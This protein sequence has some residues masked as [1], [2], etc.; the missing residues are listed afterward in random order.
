V[1]VYGLPPRTPE[2]VVRLAL[3]RFGVIEAVKRQACSR[4]IKVT[5]T[6]CFQQEISVN[7]MLKIGPTAIYVGNEHARLGRLGEQ[8]L[9]WTT[10]YVKKLARLPAK[11]TPLDLSELL[12]SGATFIDVPKSYTNKGVF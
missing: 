8:R 5:F 4:G 3:Q 1:E 12:T 9:I 11:T 10:D 2:T 6:V 7:E